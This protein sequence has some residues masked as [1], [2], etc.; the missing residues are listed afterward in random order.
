MAYGSHK[1]LTSSLH[2]AK[3]VSFFVALWYVMSYFILSFGFPIQPNYRI[4]IKDIDFVYLDSY[5]VKVLYDNSNWHNTEIL[6]TIYSSSSSI[7]QGR[8]ITVLNL[9]DREYM[10]WYNLDPLLYSSLAPEVRQ[11]I[12]LSFVPF[13]EPYKTSQEINTY[14]NTYIDYVLVPQHTIGL[15]EAIREFVPMQRF[16]KFILNGESTF[17]PIASYAVPGNEYYSPDV[18]ILYKKQTSP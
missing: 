17:V 13:I 9:V 3:V 4:G 10:N 15:A 7:E 2:I 1:L 11:K 16:Q 6:N 18:Y 12:K 8:D 14:L 5:P